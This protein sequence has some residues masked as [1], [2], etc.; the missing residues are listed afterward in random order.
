MGKVQSLVNDYAV[1]VAEDPGKMEILR[2]MIWE[3]VAQAD[4]NKDLEIS[5][6]QAL[7][8]FDGFMERLHAYIEE[9]A[10]TM[11]N[12]GLHVM[13]T[14]PEGQRLE[15][16]VVQ[17]TRLANG[18]T[19]SLHEAVVQSMGFDY[20]DVLDNRGKRPSRF[21]GLS[22]ADIIRQ[23]HEK[24]MDLV[25]GLAATGFQPHRVSAV[26]GD[27]LER[28]SAD[29]DNEELR[30]SGMDEDEAFREATFRVCGCP[31]GTYG[32]GVAE[33]VDSKNWETQE[34]LGNN[35]IR[36]SSHAYGRGSYGNQKP[37]AYRRQLARMDVTVKNEDSREYDMM[38]CTDYY[39]YYCQYCLDVG[40]DGHRGDIIILKTAKTLAV[41]LAML[42]KSHADQSL[43][44]SF[45]ITPMAWNRCFPLIWVPRSTGT[46]RLHCI[47]MPPISLN[48]ARN[49]RTVT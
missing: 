48:P 46:G 4:L 17:L 36:Y 37:D 19:P 35:Y 33:L 23:A 22:G 20:N 1:A 8:D 34:D 31:P 44:T 2:P 14:S 41:A 11:I 42:V 29:I 32:A 7:E 12:D 40:V 9:L 3:A 26:T 27:L 45:V 24:A 47:S 16:F 28:P 18:S 10:D 15:E 5:R 21:G 39:N 49:S 38:S 25:R 6:E 30:R 43:L 13:G